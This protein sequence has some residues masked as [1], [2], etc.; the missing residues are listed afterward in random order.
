MLHR[1]G[2]P[3]QHLW[4]S[5]PGTALER[6]ARLFLCV[7]CRQQVVLCSHCDHG[8][9]YCSP[10]CS[11][12]GR[13]EHRRRSAQ[14]Y[15]SSRGGRLKHAARTACWRRRQRCLGVASTD[16]RVR[17]DVNKVTHQ[18][19]TPMQADAS[20][21]ACKTT[22]ACESIDHPSSVADVVLSSATPT[23]WAAP[24]C[25]HCSCAVR[26]HLRQDWL[27]RPRV[28]SGGQHDHWP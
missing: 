6:S 26:P 16:A 3:V 10:S 19:C 17:A 23:T 24:R 2:E 28:A 20:L 27:R 1:W 21:P 18:G 5:A 13:H 9:V 4:L 14:R 8:Q 22:S 11:S 15:Q 25:R 12:A 7:R